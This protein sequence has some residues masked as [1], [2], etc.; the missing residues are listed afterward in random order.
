MLSKSMEAG[1]N[2]IGTVIGIAIIAW[3]P[4]MFFLGLFLRTEIKRGTIGARYWA[5]PLLIKPGQLTPAGLQLRTVHVFFLGGAVAFWVSMFVL[6]LL[7][8]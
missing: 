5:F 7:F 3:F 2:T 4:L 1:L 8:P 6:G